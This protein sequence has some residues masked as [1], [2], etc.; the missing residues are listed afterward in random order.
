MRIFTYAFDHPQEIL[1]V[2]DEGEEILYGELKDLSERIGGVVGHRLVFVLCRNTPGSLLGYLGLLSSGGVPLLLDADLAPQLLQDLMTTYHPAFCLVPADLPA[3]TMDMITKGGATDADRNA[4]GR[5]APAGGAKADAKTDAAVLR[6]ETGSGAESSGSRA[7]AVMKIRDYA[8]YRTAAEGTDPVLAPE[9]RLLLTTSGSTGSSK[10]VRISGD[11]LDANAASIIEYLQITKAERPITVLPM[12]YSYGMSIIHTHVMVG[13]PI[14]LTGYTLMEK[15]FWDRVQE[16]GVTSLCGVP[17]TFEM[18][19]RMGLM[20][21]NLPDLHYITQAGGKLPEKRHMEYARWCAEK[22]I[23]FYVMYGQTE[24]S[25]RMGWLP[26]DKAIEKCGSMG[27]SIP[28]GRIDLVDE[29]GKAIPEAGTCEKTVRTPDADAVP[30]KGESAA[31]VNLPEERDTAAVNLSEKKPAAGASQEEAEDTLSPVGELVYTGPNVA[32]GYALCAEDLA[33]GDEFHGVLHTGD[34]ARRDRD[35][36]FYIVGRR[37]R[38]IKMA[39]KRIGLDQVERILRGAFP[40][41]DLACAGK[42]DDLHVY[43][44]LPGRQ[45]EVSDSVPGATPGA[46]D[47]ETGGEGKEAAGTVKPEELEEAAEWTDRIRDC[48]QE[49]TVIPDRRVNVFPVREIPRSSSGKIRYAALT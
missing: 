43:V 2:T 40:D 5:E 49:M 28:G 47:G 8:L 14:I 16:E 4:A 13:A 31:A 32:L 6:T 10:L 48:I 11:N 36:Y 22:G 24:A 38:F 33:K 37:S 42:D 41:L 46:A 7:E 29:N 30:A 34:M 45:T 20:Q 21:M 9:L 23:R 3:Q 25:P 12:Q 19:R 44:V 35:G 15:G 27:I 1:A 26:P 39:G 18:Y 17:Y